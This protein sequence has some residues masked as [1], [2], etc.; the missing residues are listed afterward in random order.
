[1]QVLRGTKRE[2]TLMEWKEIVDQY[3][4]RANNSAKCLQNFGDIS[5]Q[6]MLI[7]DGEK[8]LENAKNAKKAIEFMNAHGIK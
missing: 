4:T 6:E 5:S 1:M 8:L 7:E 3:T 2:G